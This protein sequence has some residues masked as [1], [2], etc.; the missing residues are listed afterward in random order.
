MEGSNGNNSLTHVDTVFII[1]IRTSVSNSFLKSR[2]I[3]A[4]VYVLNKTS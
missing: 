1:S 4:F 2:Q 3:L